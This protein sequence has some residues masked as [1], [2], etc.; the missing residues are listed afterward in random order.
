MRFIALDAVT[1]VYPSIP[2]PKEINIYINKNTCNSQASL[3]DLE[4]IQ[5]ELMHADI[6][7]RL[8][9]KG[10]DG[11]NQD[12]S[13]QFE[14]LVVSAF[15]I[16]SSDIQHFELLNQ[17]LVPLENSLMVMNGNLGSYDDY[18]GCVEMYY[19]AQY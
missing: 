18:V 11:S 2:A 1:I 19:P 13:F 15:G 16:G 14:N 10:W 8:L 5:Q 6:I 4:T 17:Y 9:M 7:Y 12:Y 3:Y